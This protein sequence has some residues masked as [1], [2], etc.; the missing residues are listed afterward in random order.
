[1]VRSLLTATVGIEEGEGKIVEIMFFIA[2]KIDIYLPIQYL[3]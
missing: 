3:F 1:M 2:T